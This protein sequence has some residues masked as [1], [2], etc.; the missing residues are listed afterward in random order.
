MDDVI[1]R[2]QRA[3]QRAELEQVRVLKLDDGY[4]ATSSSRRLGSYSL[5]RA[6][7]GWACECIANREYGLPCKHLWVLAE[8]L[9]LDLLSDIRLNPELLGNEGGSLSLTA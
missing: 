9:D 6:P 7:D 8:M 1:K 3:A 2:W 5:W 4:R